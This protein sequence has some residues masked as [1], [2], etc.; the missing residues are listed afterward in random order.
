M[1][2][3]FNRSTHSSHS[4]LFNLKSHPSIL[5][6]RNSSK[7]PNNWPGPSSSKSGSSRNGCDSKPSCRL[8][9]RPRPSYRLRMTGL[10]SRCNCSNCNSCKHNSRPF[11]TNNSSSSKPLGF[12]L[13]SPHPWLSS[14]LDLVARTHSL[15]HPLPP[16]C[17]LCRSCRRLRPRSLKRLHP[18]DLHL[19]RHRF[20]R[21]KRAITQRMRRWRRCS[22]TAREDR[23]LLVILATCGT[24]WTFL[25]G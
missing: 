9:L 25:A 23:T 14:L 16:L 19:R 5:I 7:R 6:L 20:P 4:L 17:Q 13:S 3:L 2:A 12:K 18:A 21:L 11:S 10:C 22:Q 1:Q 8:K 24:L 15:S